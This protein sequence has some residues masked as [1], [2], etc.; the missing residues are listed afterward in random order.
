MGKFLNCTLK[1]SGELSHTDGLIRISK[2]IM[3][4]NGVRVGFDHPNP[5]YR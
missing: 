3:E 5:E 1:R 2:A 4:K